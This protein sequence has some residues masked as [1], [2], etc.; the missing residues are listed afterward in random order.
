MSAALM[1]AADPIQL[2]Q[3]WGEYQ[4]SLKSFLYSKVNHH[5]DVEDLLQEILIKTYQNLSTLKD[6]DSIKSWLFQVANRTIIDFYRKRARNQRAQE[7][8][9]DDLWFENGEREL[10]QEMSACIAPFIQALP[11]SNASLLSAVDLEGQSQKAL[12]E[13]E[14]ISYSTLKSRVQ[15]SRGELKALFEDC[16]H[17]S[18]DK[19]GSVVDYERKDDGKCRQC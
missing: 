8:E 11:E 19:N 18:L 13:A 3:V 7:L 2:E 5:E 15:K 12:A 9:T 16:C 4:Q 1:K 10:E 17:F 6:A 14:G